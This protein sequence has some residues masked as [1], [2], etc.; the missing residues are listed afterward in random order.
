M[1]SLKDLSEA[2]LRSHSLPAHGDGRGKESRGRVLVVSGNAR[3]PGAAV[4]AGVAALRAGA[5]VLQIA[6]SASMAGHIGVA[7]PEAMVVGYG[8]TSRGEIDPT[9]ASEI[10][11]LAADADSI[12]VGPG[13]MDEAA[14]LPLVTLLLASLARPT[15][16]LDAGAFT[17]LRDCA[18]AKPHLNKSIV[19]P[20]AGEMARFL[21]IPRDAVEQD[22][23]G[24]ARQAS[25]ITGGVVVMKGEE[26]IIM[27]E[28]AW[29]STFGHV[30][31]ATSGSGDVLAGILGG[32]LAR[33]VSPTLASLWAV[34][35]HGQAGHRLAEKH[36]RFGA[37][38]RELPDEIPRLMADVDRGR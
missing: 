17:C 7:V 10:V 18:E 27:G 5:G 8:E 29:R 36:G 6:T 31:L 9:N 19:T 16:V 15:I 34:Y 38:A 4:L 11:E 26:T 13:M 12:V 24:A 2:Y 20:H 37:L 33:G 28:G 1:T 30:A 14:L 32:L 25:A 22:P 35:L 23:L 21:S 3:V